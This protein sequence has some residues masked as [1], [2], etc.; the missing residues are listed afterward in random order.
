MC[1]TDILILIPVCA[2]FVIGLFKGFIKEVASLLAIILGI[3][4]ARI[5]SPAGTSLLTSVFG[6]SPTVAKPLSWFLLFV[7]IG[8]VL[9]IMSHTLEK[10]FSSLSLGGF[11]KLLGGLFGAFKYALIVSVIVVFI[12]ILDSKFSFI[13]KDTREQSWFYKPMTK[14]APALWEQAKKE[15]SK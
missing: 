6:F 1:K 13:N 5:L 4:G 10:I 11:N 3:L 14:L 15:T 8:I 12:D 2:G 9:L 7:T